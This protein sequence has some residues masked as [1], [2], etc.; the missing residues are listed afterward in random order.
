[1]SDVWV[2]GYGSLVWRPA[3]EHIERTPGYVRGYSRRFW[4]GSTD[5][6]GVPGAPGRVVTLLPG[7][8]DEAVWGMAYRLHAESTEEI[9][10]ALDVREQGGYERLEL[11]VQVPG[12]PRGSVRA[13]TYVATPENSNYLGPA[14]LEQIAAQI[15][16][17]HGPSGANI[18]YVLELERALC[19]LGAEDEH[20]R[21][22]AA[23]IRR[24]AM[25]EAKKAAHE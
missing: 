16:K 5:H 13:L 21:E 24:L 18:D 8:P 1:M 7:P 23:R 12:D 9:L 22:L 20:V 25:P 2:F 3:F 17:S 19:E 15:I 4:Q 10:G 14:P 6:R 11:D